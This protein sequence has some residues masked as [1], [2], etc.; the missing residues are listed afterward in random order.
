MWIAGRLRQEETT[1]ENGAAE[2]GSVTIGGARAGVLVRGEERD[3][4][5]AAPGGIVWKP[6]S[7]ERVLV[8]RGGT[9]GEER[10]VIGALCDETAQRALADGEVCLFAASG[11]A[12]IYLRGN[13]NVEIEGTL[14][15]N[16]EKY[17]AP[18]R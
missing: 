4:P 11:G 17:E 10:Y 5:T 8:V 13:G 16:G 15:I 14:W 6:K 1:R 18:E 3:I 2:C 7:G 9:G 12:R